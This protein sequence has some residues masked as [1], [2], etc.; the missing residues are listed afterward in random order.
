MKTFVQATQSKKAE[1]DGYGV[2]RQND[3]LELTAY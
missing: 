1:N 2:L 3:T